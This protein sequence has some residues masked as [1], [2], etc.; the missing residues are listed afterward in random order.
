VGFITQL[1]EVIKTKDDEF[2]K[3]SD[4]KINK[5]SGGEYYTVEKNTKNI[6]RKYEIKDRH[7]NVCK[8]CFTKSGAEDDALEMN[9]RHTQEVINAVNVAKQNKNSKE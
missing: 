3:L 5:V 9:F 2:K 4:D 6:F 1:I 7:G 8:R